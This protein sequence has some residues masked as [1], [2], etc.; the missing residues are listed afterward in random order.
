MELT[1]MITQASSSELCLLTS[2]NEINFWPLGCSKEAASAFDFD[3]EVCSSSNKA[4]RRK[5]Y[6]MIPAA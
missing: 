6:A 5:G 1:L 2:S 3:F 4:G